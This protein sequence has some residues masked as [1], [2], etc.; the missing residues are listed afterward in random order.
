MQAV[1]SYVRVRLF[2]TRYTIFFALLFSLGSYHPTMYYYRGIE[3]TSLLPLGYH[4]TFFNLCLAN[5]SAVSKPHPTEGRWNTY[6]LRDS[7]LLWSVLYGVHAALW[8]SLC[9]LPVLFAVLL[10]PWRCFSNVHDMF[11][12]SKQKRVRA[13]L[14]TPCTACKPC[15]P[16]LG[17]IQAARGSLYS[18]R[19]L[20]NSLI[21]LPGACVASI[22]PPLGIVF[23]P[24]THDNNN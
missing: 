8:W 13:H 24:Y 21:T 20:S 9:S 1:V 7:W 6:R 19:I 2:I 5:H 10:L 11:L 17:K 4:D 16:C 22:F 14:S 15:V 3:Q 12:R 18:T 23:A